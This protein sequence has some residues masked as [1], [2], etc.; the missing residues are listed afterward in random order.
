MEGQ[1]DLFFKEHCHSF[2]LVLHMQ[3]ARSLPLQV[4]IIGRLVPRCL[5]PELTIRQ[6]AITAIQTTLKISSCIPGTPLILTCIR[7]MWVRIFNK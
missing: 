4:H 2:V 3:G 1:S 7:V 5:D 6:L